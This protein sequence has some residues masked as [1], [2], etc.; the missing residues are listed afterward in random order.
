MF[1][2]S[3]DGSIVEA[4]AYRGESAAGGDRR[5]LGHRLVPFFVR[6]MIP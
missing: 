4:V 6:T 3:L 1:S 2:D 5:R